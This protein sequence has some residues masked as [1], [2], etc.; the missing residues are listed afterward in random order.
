[1]PHH[2]G[3]PAGQGFAAPARACCPAAVT[4]P[5][6]QAQLQD[7]TPDRQAVLAL[8]AGQPQA[9]TDALRPAPDLVSLLTVHSS[10]PP[11]LILRI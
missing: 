10:S 1:M 9:Q 3:A 8:A 6:A 11:T 5:P 7:R 2:P 4:P